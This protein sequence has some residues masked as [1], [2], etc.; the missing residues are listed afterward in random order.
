MERCRGACRVVEPEP[1]GWEGEAGR[2][3]RRVKTGRR[4]GRR[5]EAAGDWEGRR[6]CGVG[7]GRVPAVTVKEVWA[8]ENCMLR[9]GWMLVAVVDGEGWR[10]VVGVCETVG[11]LS[12]DRAPCRL[13]CVET[14]PGGAS[15]MWGGG[16]EMSAGVPVRWEC[17]ITGSG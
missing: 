12:N 11:S 7:R 5:R 15:C 2:G 4:R 17:L 1:G 6:R 16:W 13:G 9:T 10:S 8:E 3:S 14:G